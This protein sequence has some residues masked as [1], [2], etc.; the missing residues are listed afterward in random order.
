MLLHIP[1][2]PGIDRKYLLHRPDKP[3]IDNDIFIHRC[4]QP[5][6]D[7]KEHIQPGIE[8]NTVGVQYIFLDEVFKIVTYQK[9]GFFCKI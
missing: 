4:D 5:G 9:A 8:L 3:G 7:M 1:K 2:Q 6:I